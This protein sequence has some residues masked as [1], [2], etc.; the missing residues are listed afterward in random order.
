M[1]RFHEIVLLMLLTMKHIVATQST[2]L[3]QA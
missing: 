1:K 3:I 2:S